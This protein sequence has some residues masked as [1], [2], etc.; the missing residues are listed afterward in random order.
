MGMWVLGGCCLVAQE[1]QGGAE[2]RKHGDVGRSAARHHSSL[3]F[4]LLLACSIQSLY[5]DCYLYFSKIIRALARDL[6]A[7]FGVLL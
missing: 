6:G 7:Y 2:R 4:L 3:L 1:G 5:R